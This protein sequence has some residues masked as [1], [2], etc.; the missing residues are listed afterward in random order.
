MTS[1]SFDTN[2]NFIVTLENGQVWRQ[3]GGDSGVA[4]WRKP[5][6]TYLVTITSGVFG[7]HNLTVKDSPGLFKVRRV[8]P[9]PT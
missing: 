6:G 4:R 5:A 3:L 9:N 2:K 8:S 7:G 1:Y